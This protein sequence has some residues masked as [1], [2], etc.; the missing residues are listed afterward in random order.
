M[1]NVEA[2]L[3]L[4][5]TVLILSSTLIGMTIKL[6]GALKE[7]DGEK[8]KN[9]LVEA[10]REAVAYAETFKGLSG[11]EKKSVALKQISEKL[12]ESKSRYDE[13]AASEAIEKVISLSKEV[14]GK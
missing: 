5:A 10:A 11:E 13:A 3:S 12:R 1:E 2:V 6:I 14:N 7:K 8:L 9:V 4:I